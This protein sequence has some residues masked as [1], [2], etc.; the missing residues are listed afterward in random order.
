MI[1][2]SGITATI[3]AKRNVLF[4]SKSEISEVSEIYDEN[5]HNAS[6]RYAK[7]IKNFR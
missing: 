2:F 3:T 1:L 7:K 6:P 4:E 5:I